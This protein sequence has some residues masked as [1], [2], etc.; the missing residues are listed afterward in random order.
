MGR[1]KTKIRRTLPRRKD[2]GPVSKSRDCLMALKPENEISRSQKYRR[3]RLG[4]TEDRRGYHANHASGPSHYRWRGGNPKPDPER[5]RINAYASVKRYPERA[6]A[7]ARLNHEIRMGR[8][9]SAKLLLCVDCGNPAKRYDHHLGYENP[10]LVQAVCFPCDG[11][12]SRARGEHK[13]NGRKRITPTLKSGGRLLDGRTW[14]E[15]PS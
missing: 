2:L 6:K 9:Q 14:D 5:R 13:L 4:I 1:T 3:R 15:F 10:L 12:R 11:K 8:I 7:R